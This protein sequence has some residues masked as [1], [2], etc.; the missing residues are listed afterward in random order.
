MFSQH[1]VVFVL[2]L[3]IHRL[4]IQRASQEIMLYVKII[5]DWSQSPV[6]NGLLIGGTI[7]LA[8]I[9]MPCVHA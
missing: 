1:G 5:L 4:K 9:I 6:G 8:A 7:I 3:L 2:W